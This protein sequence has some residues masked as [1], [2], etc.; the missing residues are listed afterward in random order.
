MEREIRISG[1]G[2][3]LNKCLAEVMYEIGR[4]LKIDAT[5]FEGRIL[6]LTVSGQSFDPLEIYSKITNAG[7]AIVGIG[8]KDFRR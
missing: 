5:P 1:K 3:V 2:R 6:S 8:S 7:Y 4:K